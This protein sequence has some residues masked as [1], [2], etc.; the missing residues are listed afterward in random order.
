MTQRKT[1][2]FEP[3][4]MNAAVSIWGGF[5]D[6]LD[7]VIGSY[8]KNKNEWPEISTQI[9]EVMSVYGI[10]M[11]ANQLRK[12]TSQQ[13]NDRHELIECIREVCNRIDPMH[14]PELM[15]NTARGVYRSCIGGK[16]TLNEEIRDLLLRL[17]HLQQL[18]VPIEIQTPNETNPGKPERTVLEGKV[19]CIFDAFIKK[20]SNIKKDLRDHFVQ[21]VS[22]VFNLR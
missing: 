8:F 13:R 10:E 5:T 19:A 1:K 18:F 17:H 11:Q 4:T 3:Y 6:P 15:L 9:H 20:N 7:K 16:P 2:R 22:R 21:D 12:V 14:I